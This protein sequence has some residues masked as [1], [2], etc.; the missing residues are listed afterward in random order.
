MPIT[1]ARYALNAVNARWGSLYDSLYGTNTLGE[2]PKTKL[3]DEE[4][5]KQVVKYA[6]LHLDN[7]APLI[8]QSWENII[9]IDLNEKNLKFFIFKKN[10]TTLK[11]PDQIKGF[12]KNENNRIN[13]LVLVKTIAL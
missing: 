6:K 2:L 11:E 3:Y 13:E 7:F 4:R 1:N 10:F 8:S 9:N 5:G 12:K